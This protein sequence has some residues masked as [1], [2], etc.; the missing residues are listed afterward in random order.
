MLSCYVIERWITCDVLSMHTQPMP[1]GMPQVGGNWIELPADTYV[2]HP[3]GD[4]QKQSHCQ[5]E[6]HVHYG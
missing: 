2:Y 5:M 1:C 6:A 4:G 3:L